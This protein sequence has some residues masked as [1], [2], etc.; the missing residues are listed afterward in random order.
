MIPR[1]VADSVDAL[2]AGASS[3]TPVEFDDSKSGARFERVVIDGEGYLLKHLDRRDDWIMRQT[4]DVG[5]IPI[6]VWESGAFDL[7]PDAIDHATIGA[8]REG[9]RGAVLLRDVGQW[10]VPAGDAPVEVAQQLQFLDH[11]AALHAATWGWHDDIGL[12][13]A[14]NRYSFFGP[15]A[16]ACEARLGFPS[17]VPRIATEGWE[18]LDDASPEL[19]DA[20]RPL[21]VAPW[22]LFDAFAETPTAFLHGDTKFG[23]LGVRPDGRTVL[24]DW[25]QTGAGPPT[26]RDRAPARAQPR[27][28]PGRAR[29][30]RDRRRVPRRARTPRCR[31]RALVRTSARAVP[32]RRHAAARL[33]EGVRRDRP[34]ARVVA[35]PRRRHHA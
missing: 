28:H 5:C 9:I 19:A 33:G 20:L 18:R 31:H 15:A 21:R 26:R 17:P 30:R 11:L 13:P 1:P 14:A 23:N 35:R 25:S 32:R 3:R 16:L 2:V 34:G 12:L 6:R 22:P 4:G 29:S 27:A 24:I 7:L 10:L 8:A